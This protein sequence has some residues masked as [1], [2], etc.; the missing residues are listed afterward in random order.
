[1]GLFTPYLLGQLESSYISEKL[2]KYK[3]SYGLDMG[4]LT[5]FSHAWKLHSLFEYRA[6]PWEESKISNEVRFSKQEF[7]IGGYHQVHLIDGAH[8]LGL[9]VFMYL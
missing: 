1:M 2:H 4:V 6:H 7:G 8:E 5:E 9:R 3:F